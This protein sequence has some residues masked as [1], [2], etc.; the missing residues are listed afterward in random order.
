[1]LS[2]EDNQLFKSPQDSRINTESTYQRRYFHNR[3]TKTSP[4]GIK[5]ETLMDYFVLESPEDSQGSIGMNN[6]WNDKFHFDQCFSMNKEFHLEKRESINKLIGTS[7]PES[8]DSGY[9]LQVQ[10][11]TSTSTGTSR[12]SSFDSPIKSPFEDGVD[13]LCSNIVALDLNVDNHLSRQSSGPKFDYNLSGMS[14]MTPNPRSQYKSPRSK[15]PGNSFSDNFM[16]KSTLRSKLQFDS[17]LPTHNG[18]EA[19]FAQDYE[20]MQPTHFQR[21]TPTL[22]QYEQQP[23][24]FMPQNF[25]SVQPVQ[26]IILPNGMPAM[27]VPM[28]D[29][30]Q[31]ER[32]FPKAPNA[33]KFNKNYS[34]SRF[35]SKYKGKA[36]AV[37][38]I[39]TAIPNDKKVS[40]FKGKFLDMSKDQNG[41]RYLQYKVS[42]DA[43]AVD[44]ILEEIE[45]HLQEL[46]VDPFGNYLFQKIIENVSTEKRFEILLKVR[47][48]IVDASIN[49]HGTRSVQKFV[50]LCVD[51]KDQTEVLVNCLRGHITKLSM[52]TNGNHIVQR[53]L[54]FF[55]ADQKKFVF[56][57]V[58]KDM[59]LIT[60]H[61]H[62]CCVFQRCLDASTEGQKRSLIDKVIENT[63]QLVKDP[64]GNYVVQ[65]VLNMCD[66]ADTDM[67]IRQILGKLP[68]LS[69]QKFS[70]NVIEKCLAH[71]SKSL[72]NKIVDEITNTP[73]LKLLLIDQYANY[74]IQKSLSLADDESALKLVKKVLPHLKDLAHNPTCA[75]RVASKAV[76]RFPYLYTDPRVAVHVSGSVE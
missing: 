64:Y 59:M 60:K 51:S 16:E 20:R 34:S 10:S 55:S 71:G 76:E 30:T 74:V 26:Q 54:Q 8:F 27:V 14:S 65:Y 49:L 66:T 46:M 40:A 42:T 19:P 69:M 68:E 47:P 41:C 28:Y 6:Q 25:T 22:N 5:P 29:V 38:K 67:I 17:A 44:I 43:E 12:D 9:N 73:K 52:D 39:A 61:R 37:K 72:K 4:Q 53:C 3:G 11:Q 31:T 15:Y 7:P 23:P 70:S 33:S 63:Y 32:S 58:Q 50:E 21:P 18:F 62:G 75:R 36:K 24:N 2:Q 57:A 45:G 48:I 56:D 35:G 1:M 13:G